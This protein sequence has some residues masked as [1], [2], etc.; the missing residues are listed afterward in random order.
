MKR[1][2]KVKKIMEEADMLISDINSE[3]Q[4]PEPLMDVDDV[5]IVLRDMQD[6][7]IA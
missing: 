2:E 3:P 6:I 1:N 7:E 4:K 5:F